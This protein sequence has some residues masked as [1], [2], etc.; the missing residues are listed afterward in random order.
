[1]STQRRPFRTILDVKGALLTLADLRLDA[2]FVRDS[3]CDS[4]FGTDD[5]YDD[6]IV[7]DRLVMLHTVVGRCV[8]ASGNVLKEKGGGGGGRGGPLNLAF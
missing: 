6:D 7:K 3:T 2:F 1:M 8:G 4:D 5:V